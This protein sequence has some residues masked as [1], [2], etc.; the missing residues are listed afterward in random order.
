M[1]PAEQVRAQALAL[2]ANRRTIRETKTLPRRLEEA[3]N[4]AGLMSTVPSAGISEYT[5]RGKSET[6]APPRQDEVDVSRR[7]SLVRFAIE[8]LEEQVDME[9]GLSPA[10]NFN[11]LSMEE[12]DAELLRWRGVKSWEVA[13]RSP[14]LG[15]T[16]RTIE[17]AR[18]RLDVRPVDGEPLTA[19]QLARRAERKR[20]SKLRLA[21]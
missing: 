10:R 16:P 9:C 12:K 14:Q 20:L 11:T 1:N 13:A 18:E 2:D 8:Q 17:K 5:T 6:V 19:E 3:I 4:R 21:A 7:L 15:A